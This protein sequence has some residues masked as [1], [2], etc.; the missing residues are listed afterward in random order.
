MAYASTNIVT[1]IG[2]L[3][4]FCTEICIMIGL[5][6]EFWCL[7]SCLSRLRAVRST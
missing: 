6:G 3:S 2:I 7:K 1:K 4:M 5:K